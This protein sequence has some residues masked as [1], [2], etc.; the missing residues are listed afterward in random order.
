MIIQA[1]NLTPSPDLR[2]ISPIPHANSMRTKLAINLAI[3]IKH[4]QITR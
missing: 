1:C 2:L 4:I 3:I